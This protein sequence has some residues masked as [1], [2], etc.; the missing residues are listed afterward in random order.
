MLADVVQGQK[1]NDYPMLLA[2]DATLNIDKQTA[3]L[4]LMREAQFVGLFVGIETPEADAL[5]AMRKEQN[6]SLPMLDSIKTLNDYGLEVTSGIILGLD[7][8]SDDTESRLKDFIELSK[9]PMLTI[10]LLQALPKTPLWDRL[11][12][13]GR[14][15]DGQTRE[16][17][18]RFLRPYDEEGAIW[19]RS[20]GRANHPRALVDRISVRDAGP[21]TPPPRGR[22]EGGMRGRSGESELVETPPHQAEFWFR[23]VG[24]GPLPAS[25]ARNPERAGRGILSKRREASVERTFPRCVAPKS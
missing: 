21:P 16:S 19:R 3:V 1:E 23:L 5:K 10:N 6:V 7:T 14:L 24:R 17:N 20:I 2:C 13:D 15:V 4:R 18:G 11:E 25:G 9:I 22:G 12:R 8:D